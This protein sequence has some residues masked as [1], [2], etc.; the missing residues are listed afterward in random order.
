MIT[1]ID[2]DVEKSEPLYNAGRNIKWYS[3]FGKQFG[4]SSESYTPASVNHR[5]IIWPRNPTPRYIPKRDEIYMYT[6]ILTTLFI[7]AKGWNQPKRSGKQY[8]SIDKWIN[9]IWIVPA[10][11]YY[12]ALRRN[13]VLTYATTCMNPENTG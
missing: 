11:K 10:M 5:V 9:K 3:H 2:R 6:N 12:S 13:E 7:M 4:N 1:S 8:K